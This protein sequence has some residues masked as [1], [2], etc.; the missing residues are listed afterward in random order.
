MF[1]SFVQLARAAFPISAARVGLSLVIPVGL[2]SLGGAG[3]QQQAAFGLAAAVNNWFL[4]VGPAILLSGFF[5]SAEAVRKGQEVPHDLLR[6]VL[7][8][9]ALVAGASLVIALLVAGLLPVIYPGD[10]T[11][12][13]ASR[14]LLVHALGNVFYFY[15]TGIMLFLEGM[16]RSGVTVGI[17]FAG[18][19]VNLV[20]NHLLF[21]HAPGVA[22]P[23][24]TAALGTLA[25]RA[26]CGVAVMVYLSRKVLA[27]RLSD[28]VFAG[29]ADT[30]LSL[31]RVGAASGAGKASEAAAFTGL[32][33]LA[34]GLGTASMASYAIFYGFVSIVYMYLIGFTNATARAFTARNPAGDER[35]PSLLSCLIAFALVFALLSGLGAA[36]PSWLWKWYAP[37]QQVQAILAEVTQPAVFATSTFALVFLGSQLCRSVG[38]HRAATL[39]LVVCYP[40]LMLAMAGYATHGLGMGLVGVVYSFAFA[41]CAALVVLG[42]IF[43]RHLPR[44][45][46]LASA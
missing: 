36:D 41:N 33:M 28:M 43:L 18:L 20:V 27:L 3:A 26:L 15:L 30:T 1:R 14:V 9:C 4:V 46:R 35:W 17:I 16:G 39:C 21:T 22:Q 5:S 38:L 10:A 44:D 31:L 32:G 42:A 29:R 8:L 19:L 2:S 40:V 45:T 37:E 7:S 34:A 11:A 24:V 12:G 13:I 6:S 23:A 25:G